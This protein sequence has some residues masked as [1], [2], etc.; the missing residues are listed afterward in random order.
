MQ[1]F[2]ISTPVS[3]KIQ[4]DTKNINSPEAPFSAKLFGSM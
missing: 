1:T 2:I 4:T 3:G